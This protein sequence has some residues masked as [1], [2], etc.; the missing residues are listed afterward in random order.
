MNACVA[1]VRLF[2]VLNT[3]AP[4]GLRAKGLLH[5]ITSKNGVATLEAFYLRIFSEAKNLRNLI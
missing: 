1:G 4:M 5:Q 3:R 2:L